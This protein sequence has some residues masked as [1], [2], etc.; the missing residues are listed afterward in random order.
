MGSG[1][2]LCVRVVLFDL[3]RV[4]AGRPANAL[5]RVGAKGCCKGPLGRIPSSGTLTK[6]CSLF[7]SSPHMPLSSS[8]LAASHRVRISYL[9]N[10]FCPPAITLSHCFL[11]S[12]NLSAI[13]N[14]T[15][16]LE[17]FSSVV[18]LPYGFHNFFFGWVRSYPLK[19]L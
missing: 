17:Y 4:S 13:F 3:P 6:V 2:A 11:F 12:H 10:I 9:T 16:A 8:C 19:S 14:E 15:A 18:G 7:F 5:V 1:R